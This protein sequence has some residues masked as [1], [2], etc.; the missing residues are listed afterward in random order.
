MFA[1]VLPENQGQYISSLKVPSQN[2]GKIRQNQKVL[3]KLDNYPFQ[4]YGMLEGR[5][6][7]M[8]TIADKE[9]NYFIEVA[10]PNGLQTSYGRS[11]KFDKELTGS[12]DIIT[13]EMRL[14]ERVFYQFRK[15]VQ[16]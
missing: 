14:I 12:A 11:I 6:Q 3:I 13:D 5:V 9:G 16:R 1:T 15:L 7:S 4:E 10:M 8:S 2:T